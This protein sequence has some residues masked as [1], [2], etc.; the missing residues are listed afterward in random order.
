[1]LLPGIARGISSH[2]NLCCSFF[3]IVAINWQSAE[4]FMQS[5]NKAFKK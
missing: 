2:E 3:H 5:V 1:M 4:S